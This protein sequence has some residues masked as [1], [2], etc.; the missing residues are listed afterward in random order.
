MVLAAC[1]STGNKSLKEETQE[2]IDKKFKEGVTTKQDL[3]EKLGAPFETSFTD[4]GL[5]IM[6]YEFTRF[7][8]KARNFIPYNFFS[9]GQDGKKKELVILLDE[10]DVVKRLSMTESK[11]EKRDGVFE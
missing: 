8:S 1:S 7:K 11:V 3:L 4:S 9:R 10:N 2:S 5:E 6:K